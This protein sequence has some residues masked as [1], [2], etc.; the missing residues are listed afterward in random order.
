MK[1]WVLS[2][3]DVRD[4]LSKF[5]VTDLY[6]D[7]DRKE[8]RENRRLQEERFKSAALPLYVILG[9][10]GQERSR[11]ASLTSKEKFLLFLENGLAAK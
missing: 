2:E 7:R 11:L 1:S 10:D 9:P 8:D 5:V 6:T 4:V 3:K